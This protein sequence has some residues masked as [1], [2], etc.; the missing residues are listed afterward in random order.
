L[1]GFAELQARPYNRAMSSLQ[2]EIEQ[3]GERIFE[4][5]DRYP[6]S[7]F[8]K[9]GFYQRM[10]AFSMRD[11][12]FKVQMF[13][14]VDVLASLRSSRDIVQHLE[15]YF[16]DMRN[17]PVPFLHAGLRTARILPWLTAPILRWNVSGMARQFIAGRNPD[18]VMNTLRK[19]RQQRIGFTVD[20]LG[21]A[22]VSEREADEY[23]ARCFE[24]LDGL[25][26]QTRGW[27]DPL[28]KNAELFPVVNVSVKISA[29]YSQMNPAD[30]TDA[31]AHLAPKLRPILRRA[32][33]VG[34]FI[35]FDMESYAH[36]NT[37]LELFRTLF[38]EPEFH[39]WPHAG[40][41]IQAYLRDAERDLRDMLDWGRARGTRFTVRLVKGAYWDYEKIKAAQNG[42]R[43]PV[44]L[45]KP[46]SDACFEKCTRILLDNEAIVTAAFGSHN[47][48]SIAQAQA[49]AE[50]LGIDKSRFEFQLLYGMAGPIKRALVEMG[51]RVREYCPVGE[52]LPG[53]SYLVRRLLENTSNEG[54]LKAKFSDKASAVQLLRDP[55]SLIGTRAAAHSR[56]GDTLDT[57]PGDTYENAPLV[58][59]VHRASQEKMQ[60]A[61]R[62][63][64]ARLGQK[65]PIV[66]DGQKIWTGSL[67][68]SINPSSP[69]QVVGA[70]AEAGIPEAEAAIAAARKAFEHW[71]RVS[72][73]HRAE[74]LERVASIMD[75]R[76]FELSAL[77]VFEVGKPWAEADGDIREA[78]DFL[79]FYAQQM[80][81]RGLPRLTQHVPGEESYQHYWPRG[82]ALVIAPWNFPMAI[83]TGMVSAA[84]VTGNTVIMKPAE[85]SAV[86]GA[87]VMEM[88]EE[89]GIPP[90][91]LNFLPGKGR[92][93]GQHLVD[94]KDIHMIAFTG[95]R[96]VGLRIWESAGKTLPGQLE[97]KRVVCEMG[98]KNAVIVDSDADLDEA[99]VDSIYSAFGY[100]GQKCS[101]LSRLIVLEENYDRVIKRL[102]EAAASLRVG[103]PET[104]GITVGP[105]IDET[106]YRRMLDTIEAGKKEATLAYQGTDIPT[107]G[108]F[109][110]PTIFTDVKPDMRLSCEEIFGPVLSVIRVRDLDE[111]IRV[112]NDT[113]YA[114]TAGFFSRSPANIERVKAELV[115][116]NVY[117][118]RS[119]TGAV[120]GRHPFGGFKM[121][122]GGT[123]AGGGDYL[124]QFLVPRVV[125]E[126]IMRH[127]FAPDTTP[128]FRPPFGQPIQS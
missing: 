119:C 92:I 20:L 57:P 99:I 109:V 74:L 19:R 64:R 62:E 16:A 35:N 124:L 40:I 100:Q 108:Y 63:V 27:T 71:C 48:R 120:V 34:A 32:R 10:M 53:M 3:R 65:Y 37:T 8:T 25:A 98:G 91:V 49:Y 41:V 9:A 101:A 39:D 14:F 123:K 103:N 38:A 7:V 111:A 115:A 122:G 82:V 113:D 58:N 117:I 84:L 23:A 75:R 118:N 33:E 104:P 87:M 22:V 1:I 78:I 110:P 44:F 76:R 88:F 79:L 56:N 17:G 46:Q 47:V 24:L 96:E 59:F 61:L 90:G 12:H 30:P 72:V 97:L 126:N 2:G 77:E 5:V 81:L 18:D 83:L 125:T 45:Q 116:G 102:V 6:E 114:L 67:I 42:W 128:E 66:I 11:E 86:C 85:Q 43:C 29:L 93:I 54:F 94:H 52:L 70:V 95:S 127:G 69:T 21:E 15:E 50:Q 28:G 121:S 55:E 31:I 89:A 26:E 36:K 73:E 51:Y 80:R 106:A 68:N 4:L 112:A 105:V 60:A 107:E 13:R